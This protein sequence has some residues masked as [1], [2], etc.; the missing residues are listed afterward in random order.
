MNKEIYIFEFMTL[1]ENFLAKF[2]ND[3]NRL[4]SITGTNSNV[5]CST[6]SLNFATYLAKYKNYDTLLIDG[7]IY[8]SSLTNWFHASGKVGMTDIILGRK[9]YKDAIM[10][11]PYKN[12]EFLS[13]GAKIGAIESVFSY[14]EFRQFLNDIT[15]DYKIVI[16]D[17]PPLNKF[18]DSTVLSSKM[19]G[20]IIVLEAEN[21]RWEVAKNA[22]EKLEKN[23][24]I[25]GVIMNKR[26]YHIP[27]WLYSLL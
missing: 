19:D 20:T 15:Q 17:A 16:F 2:E 3:S 10:P 14:T 25:F 9:P 21:T 27:E 11:T 4:I 5:G 13:A 24:K 18:P 7:D 12:L 23:G 8:N 6:I 26:K 1:C 22:K